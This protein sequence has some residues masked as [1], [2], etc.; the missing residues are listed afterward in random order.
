MLDI[1]ATSIDYDPRAEVSQELF[2]VVQNK[3]HW[4]SHGH[5]AAEIISRRADAQQ[6]NMGL[7][8][9]AGDRPRLSDVAHRQEL[10]NG[11]GD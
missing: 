4:A 3:M 9:W 8:T 1:Y 7:T 5:T 6:P 2:K 11:R 10:P